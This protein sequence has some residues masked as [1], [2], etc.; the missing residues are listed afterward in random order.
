MAKENASKALSN[1]IFSYNS[2]CPANA[3]NKEAF[4]AILINL[5]RKGGM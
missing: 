2:H 5:T 3:S 4:P 1:G